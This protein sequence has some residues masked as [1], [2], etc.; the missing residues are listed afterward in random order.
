MKAWMVMDG[1]WGSTGKGL[2]AGY[3]AR[4]WPTDTVIGQYGPNAGHTFVFADGRTVMTR[5]LPTGG[6][7]SDTA[8]TIMMGPGSIIDPAVLEEELDLFADYLKGKRLFIHPR[9]AVVLPRHKEQER[10]QL[11]AIS[12]TQKGTG[13]AQAEKVMR[14]PDVVAATALIGTPLEE[15]VFHGDWLGEVMKSDWL[16]IESAQGFELGVNCGSSYPYCTARDITP[17]TILNDCGLPHWLDFRNYVVVRTYPIRVGHQYDAGGVKIGDSGPVYSDQRE[18]TWEELG[19]PQERTTVTQKVRRVFTFSYE[20][21]ARM[22]R[23]VRPYEVF[24]NFTNYLEPAPRFDSPVTGAMIQKL[25]EVARVMGTGRV[26]WIGKG[27]RE[28]DVVRR[29]L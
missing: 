13:A 20:G 21:Y 16:Q 23:F 5:M 27:P 26:G 24:L 6:V 18:L 17:A 3:L 22:L 4:Q 12:S 8:K 2:L 15:F 14:M 19:V 11:A 9:A 28:T 25:D 10:R 7:V 29:P 1:Q